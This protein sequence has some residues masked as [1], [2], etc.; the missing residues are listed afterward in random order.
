MSMPEQ[1]EWVTTRASCTLFKVFELLSEEIRGDVEIINARVKHR[2]SLEKVNNVIKVFRDT[3]SNRVVSFGVR[4]GRLYAEDSGDKSRKI[5]A[6]LALNN[7]GQCR[8]MVNG[9][10]CERWGFRM[11]ALEHL[12]FDEWFV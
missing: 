5:E 12:F 11:A 2:F 6:T 9:L 4:E 8:L 3:D 7:N 1:F 10:E